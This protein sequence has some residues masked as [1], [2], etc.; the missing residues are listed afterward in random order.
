MEVIAPEEILVSEISL[1]EKGDTPITSEEDF[2]NSSKLEVSITNRISHLDE[3]GK[4]CFDTNCIH[5]YDLYNPDEIDGMRLDKDAPKGTLNLKINVN[6]NTPPDFTNQ[7][8]YVS[9]YCYDYD[10]FHSEG[11]DFFSAELGSYLSI[12][13]FENY[14]Q[15]ALE[16]PVGEY[17]ILSGGCYEDPLAFT[18]NLYTTNKSFVIEEGKET[19]FNLC[20]YDSNVNPLIYPEMRGMGRAIFRFDSTTST[21]IRNIANLNSTIRITLFPDYEI[22]LR[23]NEGWVSDSY[24]PVG[25]YQIV[26]IEPSED[27]DVTIED[28]F[29]VVSQGDYNLALFVGSSEEVPVIET[30]EIVDE[31]TEESSFILYIILILVLIAFIAVVIYAYNLY[32]PQQED[33]GD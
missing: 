18:L 20:F 12:L 24:L 14:Y 31:V 28:H 33:L 13:T 27:F 29:L 2:I 5:L 11:E 10:P 19:D 4:E 22:I 15:E 23:A 30:Q 6:Q 1:E 32:K 3:L 26:S 21:Q 17:I 9:F 8:L 16:L 7:T 25:E